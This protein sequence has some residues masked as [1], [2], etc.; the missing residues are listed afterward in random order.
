ME[1][2]VATKNTIANGML[3]AKRPFSG[4]P[5]RLPA[6]YPAIMGPKIGIHQRRNMRTLPYLTADQ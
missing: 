6:T 1:T 2:I 5:A 3:T 4:V